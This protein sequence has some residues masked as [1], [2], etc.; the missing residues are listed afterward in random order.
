MEQRFTFDAVATAY[1]VARPEYP[2]ALIDD[3]VVYADLA[4]TDKILEVGCGTGQATK[5]F[6]RRGFR[7]VAID[8][9]AALLR[10]AGKNLAEFPQ[11][12]LLETTFEA[13]AAT[14]AAFRLLV[15]AQSW[16]W[17]SPEVRF[18][19]AAE[20]LAE[21][22]SLAVFGNVPVGLPVTIL[23]DFKQIYLRRTGMWGPPPEAWYLRDGPVKGL[24]DASGL[25]GPVTHNAYSWKCHYT[26]S[27]Y[28][29][30]LT[31]QSGY[32]ML[33]PEKR[34]ALLTEITK[35]IDRHGG[36]FDMEYQAHLYIA[37]RVERA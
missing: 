7:I 21:G 9:G 19:K 1:T 12:E 33:A 30:F 8:P 22:G 29:S 34:E 35:A 17:V 27:S 36:A 26:T 14:P 2:E 4:A 20:V 13:L 32:R 23:E 24:F 31:T 37:R 6:G 11:I 28:G 18:V 5:S 3:V 16:H 10:A 15:A 25:F